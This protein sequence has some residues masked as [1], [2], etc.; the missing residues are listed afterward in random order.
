MLGG[1]IGLALKRANL[2]KQVFGV[3]RDAAKL[4]KAVSLK[5]IDEGFCSIEEGAR[6]SDLV[7][8]C[9]PVQKVAD[10]VHQAA[11]FAS[12]KAL[13]TDVGSTKGTIVGAISDEVASRQFIGSHPLAGS[14]RSG[15]ENADADL[16]QNKVVILTPD[17]R[18]HP[19]SLTEA[20]KL[21]KS[22]GATVVNM[23]A[24]QHDDAVA[25]TSHLPHLIASACAFA[26]PKEL[27]QLTGTGWFDTTR[28]A[29][30]NTQM[31]R[32]II[33]ENQGPVLHV[34]KNFATIW[35]KIIEAIEAQDFDEL[36]KLL[37]AGKSI[38][39]AVGNRHS[40]S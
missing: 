25:A 6:Q 19:D 35:K 30:G 37:I 32:Q 1:S 39:D 31:W 16:F 34:A 40:S 4:Y 27:L 15:V 10:T 26:T 17:H 21:W 12:P 29:S 11:H 36:E 9:T 7:V 33:E 23:S 14:D 38:R 18:T 5:A 13:I 8:V 2:A 20:T 22:I 3:G 24:K 28:V